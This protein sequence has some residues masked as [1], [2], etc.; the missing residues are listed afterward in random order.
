MRETGDMGVRVKGGAT[1][2][3]VSRLKEKVCHKRKRE[4]FVMEPE[5]TVWDPELYIQEFDGHWTTNGKGHRYGTF[6]GVTGVWVPA[7]KVWKIQ[8]RRGS[9]VEHESVVQDLNEEAMADLQAKDNFEELSAG[10]DTPSIVGATLESCF[11][12]P[13]RSPSKASGS[14]STSKNA[15]EELAATEK[16]G[17]AARS[18]FGVQFSYGD[19]A[20]WGSGGGRSARND[21]EAL[22]AN[23]KGG[24]S[25]AQKGQ[26]NSKQTGKP[27]KPLT[28]P[29]PKPAAGGGAR[30]R[31]TNDSLNIGKQQLLQFENVTEI[32]ENFFG[33]GFKTHKQFLGRVK[34]S[35]ESKMAISRE[36]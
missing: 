4:S 2:V 16:A 8:R 25:A 1:A 19:T 21:K 31:P 28:R 34:S 32:D 9:E 7:K 33:D 24:K 13:L 18:P 12:Q 20:A 3:D 11:T 23:K 15:D 6:E 26:T 36:R 27:P 10:L 5:D 30:G 14:N 29:A 22:E 17:K 35:L